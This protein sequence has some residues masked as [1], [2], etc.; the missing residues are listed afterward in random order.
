[1]SISTLNLI[2]TKTIETEH[3]ILRAFRESDGEYMYKNWASDPDVARYV[4]W[5]PHVSPEVSRELC[6]IWEEDAKRSDIFNWAMVLK[7]TGEPIGGISVVKL[8]EKISEADIGYCMGQQWW[9]KGYMTEC[10]KAVIK[11]L[12]MEVNINRISACHHTSNPASGKVM[13][14]CGL[15]PEGIKRQG[16]IL[17]DELF[18]LAQYAILRSDYENE[19]QPCSLHKS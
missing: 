2:G 3:F 5:E 6:R 18:D 11:F 14:K 13:K 10:F 9:N 19:V 16:A 17:N 7:E 1:M 15:R 8:D 12:F 4:T